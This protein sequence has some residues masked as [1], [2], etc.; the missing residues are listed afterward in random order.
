[1]APTDTQSDRSSSESE[2]ELEPKSDPQQARTRSQMPE[3]QNTRWSTLAELED[4][5][6]RTGCN[7]PPFGKSM[8][9]AD[10]RLVLAKYQ[11]RLDP[12]RY[13]AR[14]PDTSGLREMVRHI[15]ELM[16]RCPDAA[17][18]PDF[19]GKLAKSTLSFIFLACDTDKY[20]TAIR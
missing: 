13:R 16:T 9:T 10:L 12:V 18:D 5:Y 1:M 14:N 7:D 17:I 8:F 6:A 11:N 2:L 15:L 4:F 20:F 3:L 19:M